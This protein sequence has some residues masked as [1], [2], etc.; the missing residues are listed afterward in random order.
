MIESGVFKSRS[1]GCAI[2]GATIIRIRD[3]APVSTM[4]LPIA[5]ER[6]SLSRAPK[7]CATMIPAP[8]E[9]PM[10]STMS[11]FR[12]GPALPTAARALSP[13]KRPTMTLSAVLYSC[14]ARL[15][16]SMGMV[17]FMICPTGEPSVMSIGLKNSCSFSFIAI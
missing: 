4:Q 15:P 3:A 12:M 16:I 8:T 2:S 1:I 6:F 7:Y 17:N 13:T 9:I 10:N 11:R 14:W 5:R